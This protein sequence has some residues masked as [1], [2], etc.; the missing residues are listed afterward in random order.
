MLEMNNDNLNQKT[1]V[2]KHLNNEYRNYCKI[3]I[4]KKL[5]VFGNNIR[6]TIDEING[7]VMKM[8]DIVAATFVDA[9]GK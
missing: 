4:E 2:L 6:C 1:R 5:K 3:L 9:T 7:M 8:V